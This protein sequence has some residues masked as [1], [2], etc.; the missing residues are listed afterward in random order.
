[1]AL[2]EGVF[3]P[4]IL[5]AVKADDGGD[6]ARLESVREDGQQSV[7]VGQLTIDQNSESLKRARRRME[8]GVGAPLHR[9]VTR[10]ADDRHKGFGG[11]DRGEGTTL[12]NESR[13]LRRIGFIAIFEQCRGKL[14]LA[15]AVHQN[16]SG[17][18]SGRVHPH[19]QWTGP[20]IGEAAGRIV[21][22]GAGHAE[23]GKNRIDAWC[24]LSFHKRHS[25]LYEHAGE[26]GEVVV[27]EIETA[28]RPLELRPCRDDVG[29]VKVH[30]DEAA[31]GT[32][33]LEYR[34]GMAA[35]ANRAVHNGL[36]GLG[37]EDI[38]DFPEKDRD[39]GGCS[40]LQAS[41]W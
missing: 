23:I 22:L 24:G 33:T 39:V 26:R 36:A 40:L 20:T 32:E 3:H 21:D 9:E 10:L 38:K 12:N 6:A 34:R 19:V 2:T 41:G 16:G 1:M 29:G 7:E 30:A 37:R 17:L 25:G 8:F 28:A 4:P 13:D 5:A 27:E 18:S 11:G 14:S 15:E 35:E 31:V